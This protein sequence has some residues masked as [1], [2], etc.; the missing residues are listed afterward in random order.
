VGRR[1]VELVKQDIRIS[2]FLT[3]R[4]FENAIKVNAA[5]GGSTNAILHLLALAGRA[6][7]PLDLEDFDRLTRDIPLLVNLQPSGQYLMEDFAYA[8]GVLAVVR[9]LG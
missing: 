2:T 5:I 6:G 4:S 8:G 9:E 1:I 3:R 7:V